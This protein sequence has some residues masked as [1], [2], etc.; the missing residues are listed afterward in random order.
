MMCANPKCN[1]KGGAPPVARWGMPR[2]TLRQLWVVKLPCFGFV[3]GS[4][5]GLGL[6]A[7]CAR[8]TDPG[9]TD[10]S[11]HWL[12]ACA[13]DAEC[14]EL[15]CLCGA[16]TRRCEDTDAC[17]GL[18]SDG[19]CATIDAD[20]CAGEAPRACVATCAN[21]A[22]CTA[23]KGGT[24]CVGGQCWP[25]ARD[26]PRDAG[27]GRDAGMQPPGPCA[28][29][30]ATHAGPDC[31]ATVGYAWDG[32]QCFDVLCACT[33][34]DCDRLFQNLGACE[35]AYLE[36]RD[37]VTVECEQPS[38]CVLDFADCCGRCGLNG[39]DRVVALHASSLA[40]HRSAV[41]QPDTSCLACVASLDP[42]VYATC[43][44]GRC[45]VLDATTLSVCTNDDD[46]YVRA[47]AC[48]ECNA[49][50]STLDGVVA[51]A[52]SDEAGYTA[53]VCQPDQL[54]DE[55]GADPYPTTARCDNNRCVLEG[56]DP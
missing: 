43:N 48:C 50:V 22:Q 30:D 44:A 36:C 51:I 54:C 34:V 49:D 1:G 16:C 24:A 7:A 52:A 5:L 15:L 29:M 4:A 47:K 35:A 38:D 6:L 39:A 28:A 23:E 25:A 42:R 21:D 32:R 8:T 41:C 33:G 12:S 19:E 11:T 13:S 20:R 37:G 55:C 56:R 45:E 3:V 53:L 31:A 40:D 18:G 17:A 27:T 46:C 9:G 14:G 2:A 26:R 10:G